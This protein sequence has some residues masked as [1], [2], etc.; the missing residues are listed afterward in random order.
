MPKFDK[1]KIQA[2]RARR[3]QLPHKPYAGRDLRAQTFLARRNIMAHADRAKRISCV[4][5]R[6][7]RILAM[8]DD[9]D[10]DDSE[11]RRN[12]RG[13]ERVRRAIPVLEMV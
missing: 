5:V 10:Q 9:R 3:I 4:L 6:K 12:D 2:D 8:R 11:G 1:G 7:W 13:S